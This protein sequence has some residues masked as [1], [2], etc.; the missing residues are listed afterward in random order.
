MVLRIEKQVIREM[1]CPK[2][3]WQLDRDSLFCKMSDCSDIVR[4]LCGE[5]IGGL[6]LDAGERAGHE[7]RM[8]SRTLCGLSQS[9][10][11]W[12]LKLFRL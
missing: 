3:S 11:L 4:G 2:V 10:E 1:V 5:Q 12:F 7:V 9:V 8:L 6:A